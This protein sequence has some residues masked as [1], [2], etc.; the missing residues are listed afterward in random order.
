L[1][2]V[3]HSNSTTLKW[4]NLENQLLSVC[5]SCSVPYY[6]YP[7]TTCSS[8]PAVY[9]LKFLCCDRNG[10]LHDVTEILSDLELSIQRVKVTTTPDDRV[11]DLFFI[12]DNMDLLHTKERQDKTLKQLQAVLG[13]S[14]TSCELQLVGPQY[15]PHHGIP[16]LSPLVAEEL[17]RCE[18]LDK[19]IRSQALSPDMT[20]FKKANVTIDNSLS[21]A[22]TL[23]QIHCADHKGLLYDIMRTLKDSNI[24]VLTEGKQKDVLKAAGAL[25][26]H[27]CE[28]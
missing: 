26:S 3:P 5:P 9:L 27:I 8:P 1:W 17:F 18:L 10:L 6:F 2:V 15:D 7:Q 16:S 22:H 28:V 19:E 25:S 21:P 24:K 13:E 12:T 4:S 20:K 14:C 23:L 11:L